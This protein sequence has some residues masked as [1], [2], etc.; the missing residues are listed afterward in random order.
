MRNKQL[1]LRRALQ[2]TETPFH[3][4]FQLSHATNYD[5][6][7]VLTKTREVD[8]P[9]EMTRARREDVESVASAQTKSAVTEKVADFWDRVVRELCRRHENASMIS[10][11]DWEFSNDDVFMLRYAIIE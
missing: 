4:K 6:K 8:L 11:Y 3:W 1:H 9:E 2:T 10:F 7:T 5:K